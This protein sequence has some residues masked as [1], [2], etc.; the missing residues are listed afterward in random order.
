M[1]A[2][3]SLPSAGSGAQTSS[4][5]PDNGEVVLISSL[6]CLKMLKHGWMELQA[7][8]PCYSSDG[9]SVVP[10]RSV[11]KP[12]WPNHSLNLRLCPSTIWCPRSI[13][14]LSVVRIGSTTIKSL[15]WVA[16]S[17]DSAKSPLASTFTSRV[18]RG[19]QQYRNDGSLNCVRV[20]VQRSGAAREQVGL[21]VP[22]D[23]RP[24]L[25][26]ALHREEWVPR[27]GCTG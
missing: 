6:A 26:G 1:Q 23:P 22:R 15:V 27:P 24:L 13:V 7:P 12:G 20:R 14:H 5:K 18:L 8:T 4:P 3:A 16:R 21:A 25:R 2:L 19:K 17:A 10:L 11:L 9:T